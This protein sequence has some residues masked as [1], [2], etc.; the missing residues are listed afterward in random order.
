MSIFPD[1]RFVP[2]GAN[3]PK[4]GQPMFRLTDRMQVY[5][6]GLGVFDVPVGSETDFMSIYGYYWVWRKLFGRVGRA[7]A[8]W[9]DHAYGVL[10]PS[11]AIT[12]DQADRGFG[13]LMKLEGTPWVVRQTVLA[14][15]RLNTWSRSR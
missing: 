10:V 2:T 6:P 12:H 4:Y 7:S 3:S 11:G 5:V 8:V 15:V 1:V 13:E 14:A 9:H